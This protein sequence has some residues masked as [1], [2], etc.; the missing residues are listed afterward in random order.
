MRALLVRVGADQTADGGSWNAPVNL[1]SGKFVYASIPETSRLHRQ[2]HRPFGLLKTA[3]A[4]FKAEVPLWLT[5][6]SM[7]LD[8]DF[9]NLTYGDGGSRGKQISNKLG[10]GDLIVFYAGLRSDVPR[11]RLVY[12]LIGIYVIR[13]II[14]ADEVPRREWDRNA[15]TRRYPIPSKQNVV[16]TAKSRVSG[17]FERCIPIGCFRRRAYRLA[18]KF[19]RA[20]GGIKIK[21]GYL[22]RSVHL[23]ELNN[24]EAFYSWIKKQRIRLLRRNN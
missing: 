20:W 9:S 22:Q 3:L 23:P 1:K 7:H 15:H 17:R 2:M 13:R 14:P 24:P 10:D 11:R 21:G 5:A 8:P 16:V 12:A 19:N 18:P 4:R 6:R